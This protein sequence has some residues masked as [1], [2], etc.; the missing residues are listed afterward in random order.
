M[1]FALC[2]F[3]RRT[4]WIILLGESVLFW[5]FWKLFAVRYQFKMSKR[6]LDVDGNSS[7]S[8]TTAKRIKEE[9]R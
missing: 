1:L 8:L 5:R 3:Y 2:Y 6:R 9:L 7:S 4:W